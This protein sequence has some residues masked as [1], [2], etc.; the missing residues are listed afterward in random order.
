MP[1]EQPVERRF[2]F[3]GSAVAF[4]GRIRRPDDV[5]VKAAA[6]SHLPVTGGLAEVTLEGPTATA[7]YHYKEV[8]TFSSAHTRAQGDFSDANRAKDFTHG[9]H[10]QNLL[11]ANTAVGSQLTGLMID[12]SDPANITPRRIFKAKNL[13]LHMEST[14][15]RRSPISFRSFSATFDG[16]TLT[17]GDPANTPVELKVH[18]ATDVFEKNDTKA[19]L[20]DT[21][22]EDSEFRKQFGSLFHPVGFHPKGAIASLLTKHEMPTS[23][24]GAIAATFVTKLEWVGKE[25]DGTE[26]LNNRLTIQGLG[27]IFFGEILV[28]EGMRRATLLRFELGSPVG[29]DASACEVVSNG[30]GIPPLDSP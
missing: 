16:I 19:K 18:T 11:P 9:N 22:Q 24:K 20:L 26:I 28:E 30:F 7:P 23:T 4:A 29:G 10:G 6:G 21:Y 17:T 12:V 14:T 1:I 25:P 2:V 27:R 13:Q 5:F 15:D 3:N 8:I